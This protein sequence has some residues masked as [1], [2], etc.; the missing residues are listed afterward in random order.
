MGNECSEQLPGSESQTMD[1]DDI[2]FRLLNQN[3]EF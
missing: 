3:E 2:N 1:E